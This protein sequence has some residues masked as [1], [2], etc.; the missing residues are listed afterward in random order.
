MKQLSPD[1]SAR[2]DVPLRFAAWSLLII[3][4]L[5]PLVSLPFLFGLLNCGMDWTTSLFR[6]SISWEILL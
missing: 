1:I 3:E 2:Y 4:L 6:R 5:L